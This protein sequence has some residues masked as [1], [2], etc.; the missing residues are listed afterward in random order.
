[1]SEKESSEETHEIANV[2]EKKIQYGENKYSCFA[3]GEKIENNTTICPYCK[4][5]QEK[6]E[7][8]LK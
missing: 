6:K 2:V 5:P 4:T 1:M 8:I 7:S 3:C